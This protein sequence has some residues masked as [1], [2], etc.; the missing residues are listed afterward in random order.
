MIT[1]QKWFQKANVDSAGSTETDLRHFFI[2]DHLTNWPDDWVT[3][4]WAQRPVRLIERTDWR[5]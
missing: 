4:D 5:N 2:D 1:D 3:I